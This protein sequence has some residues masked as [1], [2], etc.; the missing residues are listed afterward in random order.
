[1]AE[2]ARARQVFARGALGNIAVTTARDAL[3]LW[4]P[5]PAGMSRSALAERTRANGL[6]IGTSDQFVAAGKPAPEAVR[7]GIRNP[8]TRAELGEALGRFTAAYAALRP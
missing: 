1:V 4:F 5:L 6:I 7:I 3:H 8:A 2:E